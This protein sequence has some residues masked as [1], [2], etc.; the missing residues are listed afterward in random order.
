MF[1][2]DKVGTVP[3][4]CLNEYNQTLQAVLKSDYDQLLELYRDAVDKTRSL[5]GEETVNRGMGFIGIP[6]S[7][8]P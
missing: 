5:G 6:S 3:S 2:P 1:D 7:H 8:V 4:V